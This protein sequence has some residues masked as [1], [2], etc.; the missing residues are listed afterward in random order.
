MAMTTATLRV[1]RQLEEALV[2]GPDPLHPAEVFGLDE[3]PRRATRTPH[4]PC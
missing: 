2:K 4:V 1:D 3:R